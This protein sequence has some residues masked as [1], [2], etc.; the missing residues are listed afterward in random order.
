MI[1][2]GNIFYTSG[3]D[4]TA[5]RRRPLKPKKRNS[6]PIP[7]D[8][9]DFSSYIKDN[10]IDD[11]GRRIAFISSNFTNREER[12]IA[13]CTKYIYA[14]ELTQEHR[15]HVINTL[16]LS[17]K[18]DEDEITDD[19]VFMDD[20]LLKAATVGYLMLRS[21]VDSMSGLYPDND[22]YPMLGEKLARYESSIPLRLFGA[23][24]YGAI[25]GIE[26]PE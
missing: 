15:I 19:K 5:Q 7:T 24:V 9:S 22:L 3:D 6:H 14:V 10:A 13:L 1:E 26:I 4:H 16:A 23:K 11:I 25:M 20:P 21:A 18:D 2:L 8:E 12:Q 17:F